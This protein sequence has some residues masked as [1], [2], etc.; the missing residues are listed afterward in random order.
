MTRVMPASTGM[1]SMR[2]RP[3]ASRTARR[4]RAL[5]QRARAPGRPARDASAAPRNRRRAPHAGSGSMPA[6]APGSR[7][8][9]RPN[10]AGRSARRSS[11]A[12]AYRPH[13]ARGDT[14]AASLRTQTDRDQREV[15]RIVE[16][17][18]TGE[19]EDIRYHTAGGIA[20]ITINR[21][22]VRNAFRPTTLFELSRAFEMA[23]DDPE[24]GVIILTGEGPD[25]FCS[26]G[27]QRIRGDDGY[28]ATLGSGDRDGS[29]S[30]TCRSRSGA[31][32][33]RS[34]RWSPATRSAAATCCTSCATSPSPQTTRDS[35]RPAR[36]SAASTPAT[37]RGCS[38]GPSGSSAPR[39]SGSSAG[40]TT[41]STRRALGP[42]QHR[43]PARAPRGGNGRGAA[44][45]CSS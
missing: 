5:Q 4:S 7:Q 2:R 35:G 36:R 39:R 13:E 14:I 41:P 24:V 20:K 37:G 3:S 8:R 19:W 33:S 34:S 45:G 17:V 11:R 12:R 18:A 21:P 32:R 27:D 31:C 10:G 28:S 16:W 26:G 15:H 30:S 22:E 25:A 9:G 29:T 43:R 44:T 40:S 38:R 1:P 23:R 6:P 42:R